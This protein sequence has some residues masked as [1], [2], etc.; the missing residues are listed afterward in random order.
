MFISVC[1]SIVFTLFCV[2]KN[3]YYKFL[4]QHMLMISDVYLY[5]FLQTLLQELNK[6]N[7]YKQTKQMDPKTLVQYYKKRYLV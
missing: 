6:I 3:G 5:Y 4:N 1:I 7:E 2:N